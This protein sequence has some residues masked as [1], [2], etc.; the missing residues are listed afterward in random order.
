MLDSIVIHTMITYINDMWLQ[1]APQLGHLVVQGTPLKSVS[2]GDLA[3]LPS[4]RSL[5]VCASP[6]DP[7]S[8]TAL[9]C[10]PHLTAL[11]VS[12]QRD[13]RMCL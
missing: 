1:V 3:A 9:T 5:S 12:A 13:L 4:L 11:Q 6:N 7:Y 10:L 2:L 8:L